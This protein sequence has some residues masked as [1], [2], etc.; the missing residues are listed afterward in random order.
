MLNRLQYSV[1]QEPY[2]AAM[3]E[4]DAIKAKVK[5]ALAEGAI[6]FR[7]IGSRAEPAERQAILNALNALKFIKR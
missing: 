7:M 1:W 2:L 6:H 3:L 5:I 4:M